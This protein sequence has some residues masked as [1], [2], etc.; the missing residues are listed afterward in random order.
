MELLT[1][2]PKVT[3]VDQL[4]K[5]NVGEKR[6]FPLYKIISIRSTISRIK[7]IFYHMQFSCKKDP[8][9]EGKERT[10]TVTRLK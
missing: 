8:V 4:R 2:S 10:V 3:L 6:S 5:M 9:K 1:D 7:T